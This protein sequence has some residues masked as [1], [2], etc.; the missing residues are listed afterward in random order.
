MASVGEG[1]RRPE[2]TSADAECLAR[3]ADSSAVAA[4]VACRPRG[5]S[6]GGGVIAGSGVCARSG[7]GS[8]VVTGSGSGAGAGGTGYA[9][10]PFSVT[11]EIQLLPGVPAGMNCPSAGAGCHS[12]SPA[13]V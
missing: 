8:G 1:G 13:V 4:A 5:T 7:V 6:A 2:S 12:E 9:D 11:G 10:E 3:R